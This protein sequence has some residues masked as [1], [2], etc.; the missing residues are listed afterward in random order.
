MVI[1]FK[2]KN[3]GFFNPERFYK[4]LVHY[5]GL[6]KVDN[7]KFSLREKQYEKMVI[8]MFQGQ[9]KSLRY[10]KTLKQL[11]YFYHKNKIPYSR[12]ILELVNK[13]I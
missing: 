13:L 12:K 3:E 10:S 9:N 8:K 2:R 11:D 6:E 7:V 5:E 1:A 4:K